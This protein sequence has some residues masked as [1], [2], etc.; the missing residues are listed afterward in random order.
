[1]KLQIAS[2]VHLEFGSAN[3]QNT[4]N[5]DVLVLAGDILVAKFLKKPNSE[6]RSL[7]MSFMEQ[8]SS[9]FKYVVW[10]AG[11]HEFY[12]YKWTETLATCRR[13]ASLFPNVY[14]LEQ[15]TVE[16]DGV[17]FWGATLWTSLNKNCPL[18][19][20]R[21][22]AAMND[23][24]QISY[25]CGYYRKL[26]PSDTSRRHA[27]S[28]ASLLEALAARNKTVVVTHHAPSLASINLKY[29][30]EVLV[31]HAYATELSELILDNPNIRAWIHGH[32][33]DNVDYMIGTTRVASNPRG[34]VGYE[35]N[36]DS[37]ASSD[38]VL[39]I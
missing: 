25:D 1:M 11:N 34:Y 2:D 23:Y 36:A 33:H 15:E 16:L 12:G 30:G 6:Q 32:L 3:I 17:T 8:C 29:R 13:F 38:L 35:T 28:V 4:T 20:N 24:R 9:E 5:S 22:G 26:Q 19:L 37:W 27:A 18:V 14:F 39:E 10:V 21:V 31:N 7:Y